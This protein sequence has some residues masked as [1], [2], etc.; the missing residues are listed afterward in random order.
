MPASALSFLTRYATAGVGTTP[1]CITFAPTEQSPAVS[2]PSS[3]SDERLVSIP[4]RTHGFVSLLLFSKSTIA[5]A[6]PIFIASSHVSSE[7]ATPLAPSVP[8]NLPIYAISSHTLK[9]VKQSRTSG[10]YTIRG[11][12]I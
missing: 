1:N 6:R 5:A 7:F 12:H 11:S 8:N 4:I 2:A 3:I 10:H 9:F